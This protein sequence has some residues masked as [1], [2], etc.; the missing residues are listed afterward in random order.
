MREGSREFGSPPLRWWCS[1]KQGQACCGP[2]WETAGAEKLDC[3]GASKGCHALSPL[4]GNG[5]PQQGVLFPGAPGLS[6]FCWTPCLGQLELH[7]TPEVDLWRAER[8]G[9][10]AG[11]LWV[12]T[13]PQLG[14]GGR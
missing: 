1:P 9:S 6:P 13:P 7:T 14:G 12:W 5:V 3:C 10:W 4:R 11:P 8:G 2:G